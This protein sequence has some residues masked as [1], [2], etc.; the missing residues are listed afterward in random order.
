MPPS[1]NDPAF[2]RASSPPESDLDPADPG[3]SAWVDVQ[4]PDTSSG[5]QDQQRMITSSLIWSVLSQAGARGMA[6]YTAQAYMPAIMALA[7]SLTGSD[8]ESLGGPDSPDARDQGDNMQ[9]SL[10]TGHHLPVLLQ[11]A[12]NNNI[13][14]NN[15]NTQEPLHPGWSWKTLL[16]VDDVIAQAVLEF[17][18]SMAI[19]LHEEDV[20][21]PAALEAKVLAT[22]ERTVRLMGYDYEAWLRLWNYPR[23]YVCIGWGIGGG[24][25]CGA[26]SMY[27]CDMFGCGKFAHLTPLCGR[28]PLFPNGGLVEEDGEEGAAWMRENLE[29]AVS[30]FGSAVLVV[31]VY[32]GDAHGEEVEEEGGCGEDRGQL[33]V[34]E[35]QEGDTYPLHEC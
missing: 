2:F 4:P 34:D 33:E 5:L 8:I 9:R 20:S 3:S 18:D 29:L 1:Q 27:V 24:R 28:S 35:E 11:G 17:H 10:L 14:I 7:G 13:N 31:A 22:L 16:V 21:S 19:T 12:N 26:R 25:S 30:G 32:E 6:H 15:S 23:A